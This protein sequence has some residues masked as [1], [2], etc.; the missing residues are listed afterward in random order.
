MSVPFEEGEMVEIEGTP[1]PR[2]SANVDH[3]VERHEQIAG[4]GSRP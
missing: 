1:E 4:G 2:E 3:Q